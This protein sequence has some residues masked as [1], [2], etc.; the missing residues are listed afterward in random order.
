MI[1]LFSTKNMTAY[2][3]LLNSKKILYLSTFIAFSIIALFNLKLGVCFCGDGETY[4]DWG[5]DLINL[6]F[7]FLSFYELFLD[8]SYAYYGF[9]TPSFFYTVP[10]TIVALV[11]VIFGSGWQNAFFV[12]N[13]SLVLLSLIIILKSLLIIGV[14]PVLIS[15]TMFILV[16]SP[17]L[18][19]WPQY[20]LSEMIFAFEV[21]FCMYIIIKGIV[22]DKINYFALIMMISLLILSRPSSVPIVFAVLSYIVISRFNIEFT[23]KLLLLLFISLFIITPIVLSFLYYFLDANITHPGQRKWTIDNVDLGMIIHMRPETY[24]TPPQSFFDIT[25]VYFIRMISFFTP[26]IKSFSSIHI[27]LNS[28]ETFIVLSSLLL[29]GFL[30]VNIKIFNKVILFI[31]LI[32]ISTAAYHSLT[33]IDYDFRYRFPLIMPLIMIFPIAM[34]ILFKRL[35]IKQV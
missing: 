8:P 26:Y 7:N 25:Y 19:V 24:V 29:W 10:V 16:A 30:K 6:N 33:V 23:P 28:I 4:S 13:L 35:K 11:K 27:I 1:N 32:T 12:I 2:I 34:E 22:K 20:I 14:R 9:F 3:H 31:L 18:L 15:L 17:D 21:L 5:N